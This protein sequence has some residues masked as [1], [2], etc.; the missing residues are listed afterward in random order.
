MF[1]IYQLFLTASII[2]M[3]IFTKP[4][5]SESWRCH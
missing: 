3:Y 1:M 2:R 4:M 5:S